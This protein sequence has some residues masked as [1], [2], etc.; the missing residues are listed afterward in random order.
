[1]LLSNDLQIQDIIIQVLL[2]LKVRDAA[3]ST[4][5]GKKSTHE[6]HM[7]LT[8]PHVLQAKYLMIVGEE[9]FQGLIYARLGS[10]YGVSSGED[11][12]TTH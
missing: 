5:S 9:M 7:M 12:K 3:V 2:D 8:F 11:A 1:M 6:R 10:I 4:A